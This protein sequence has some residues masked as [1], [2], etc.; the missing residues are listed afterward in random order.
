MY[1]EI[2][3]IKMCEDAMKKPDTFYKQDFINYRGNTVNSDA[4]YTEVIA[5]FI[6]ENLSQYIIPQITREK[7]YF[8]DGHDGIYSPTS[9]REEEIIAMEL[10]KRSQDGHQYNFIGKIIDY[11]TPLKNKRSDEA[12]KIDLLSFD[13][14]KLYILELKKPDSEESML[15]C[16]LEG[17][18]YLQTVDKIKLLKDFGLP[19]NINVVACPFVFKNGKQHKEMQENRPWLF[20]LMEL[21]NSKPYYIAENNGF[22]SVEE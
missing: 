20:K 4:P 14:S 7:S 15:R 19:E 17:Y 10:F 11:Q 22:Y 21:L 12:G 8:T 2:Q 1:S 16:V 9:N 13:D 3:I 6:L 18:T 5:K